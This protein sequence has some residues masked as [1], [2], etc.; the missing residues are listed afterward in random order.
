MEEQKEQEVRSEGS[1]Q[2]ILPGAILLAALLISGTL[3]FTR[4]GAGNGTAQIGGNI[5]QP[6]ISPAAAAAGVDIKVTADDHVLG[7]KNAK[8]TVVEYADFRCPFCER[9]FTGTADPIIKNYVNTGKVNF[10][11]RNY[12]FLGQQSTWA[13]EASECAS[14]QGKFWPYHDWLYKNQAPESDLNYYSKENLIKYAGQVGG[15]NTS[16]FASCLNGGKYT[17]KV[18]DALAGGKSAGVTGTPTTFI[19]GKSIV[20]ARPYEDFKTAIEAALK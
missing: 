11:F 4:S 8:V 14:E 10:V 15:I 13:S 9:F 3:I 5:V 18:A 16:Q 6:T 1:S 12:A 7:N 17:K 2:Y 19:N 20:G